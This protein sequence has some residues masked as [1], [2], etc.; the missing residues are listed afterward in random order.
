MPGRAAGRRRP[1]PPLT[2][3][4]SAR[5]RDWQRSMSARWI[6]LAL[7]ASAIVAQ[8]SPAAAERAA[9]RAQGGVLDLT[10][11]DLARDGIVGLAGEWKLAWGRFEDP[12]LADDASS[13]Q[14]GVQVPG[15]WNDAT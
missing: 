12:T 8:V 4:C 5:G 3:V 9:P 11:W 10:D 13:T 6:L 2:R 15:A 7:C 14:T 1:R